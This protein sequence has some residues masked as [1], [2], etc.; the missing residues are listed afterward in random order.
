MKNR[1]EGKDYT[2]RFE[3]GNLI[4]FLLMFFASSIVICNIVKMVFVR[5]I[6][7][8]ISFYICGQIEIRFMVR[9]I[10]PIIISTLPKCIREKEMKLWKEIRKREKEEKRKYKSVRKN[11]TPKT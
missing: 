9:I 5:I 7:I 8:S 3:I 1:S 11:D 4:C 2:I 10:N 6:M